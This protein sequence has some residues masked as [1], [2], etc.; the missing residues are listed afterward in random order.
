[1]E[2]KKCVRLDSGHGTV[3]W[4]FVSIV[5]F[6]SRWMATTQFQ[7][8]HARQAFPCY[9]EP[10][11]KATFDIT[12]NREPDFSPTISNMPIKTTVT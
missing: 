12:M 2:P 9:D 6:F 3:T 10:G 1:M 5:F 8:G 7:P 4:R 11:F